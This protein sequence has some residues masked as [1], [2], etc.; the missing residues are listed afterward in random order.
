MG[1]GG[2]T[3]GQDGSDLDIYAIRCYQSNA[4]EATEVFSN[5]VSTL[6]TTEQKNAK[7]ERNNILTSGKVDIVKVHNLGIR[8]L[9]QHG[10]I[11]YH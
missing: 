10:S 6:P 5:Y 1:N 4:L 11:P 8:T 9:V 7:R 3:L 2:L